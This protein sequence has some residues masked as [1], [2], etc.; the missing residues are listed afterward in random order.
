MGV[1]RIREHL[2]L[3]PEEIWT[4]FQVLDCVAAGCVGHCPGGALGCLSFICLLVLCDTSSLLFVEH[5][6]PRLLGGLCERQGFQ[7]G[8]FVA[9]AFCLITCS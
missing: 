4:L 3:G 7:G 1:R 8:P 2:A 6:C 5:G 9:A